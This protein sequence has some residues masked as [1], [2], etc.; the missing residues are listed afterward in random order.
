MPQNAKLKYY[1]VAAALGV[2]WFAILLVLPWM[3]EILLSMIP[4]QIL[5]FILTSLILA[6][7]FYRFITSAKSVPGDLLRAVV[8]PYVGCIIYLSLLACLWLISPLSGQAIDWHAVL[9]LYYWGFR[10]ALFGFFVIIPLGLI[11]QYIMRRA[12]T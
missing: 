12:A 3:R 1:G 10:F 9:G 11:S 7:V 6:R 8:L 4:L 2:G 5:F